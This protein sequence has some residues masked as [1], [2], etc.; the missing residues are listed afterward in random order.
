LV[1][2]FIVAKDQLAS[3][4]EYFQGRRKQKGNYYI[5][6]FTY[7]SRVYANIADK[8]RNF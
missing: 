8:I 5:Q 1:S 4:P 6:I 2:G 7:F 3:A